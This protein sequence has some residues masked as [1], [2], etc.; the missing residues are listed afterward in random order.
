M[1]AQYLTTL[2]AIVGVVAAS[3][4][5][6]NGGNKASKDIHLDYAYY[7]PLSLV[8]RDQHLLENRGYNVTWGAF[9]GKQ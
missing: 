5:G 6:S 9:G 7:S 2:L 3:G 1:K 4:C 8:V